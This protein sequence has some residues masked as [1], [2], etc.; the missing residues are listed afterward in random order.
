M[1]GVFF[2]T[3]QIVIQ[4][5]RSRPLVVFCYRYH[6]L[7]SLQISYKVARAL[8]SST[9]SPL[10]YIV[11]FHSCSLLIFTNTLSQAGFVLVPHSYLDSPM[12]SIFLSLGFLS[13]MWP[14]RSHKWNEPVVLRPT[15][16]ALTTGSVKA[17]LCQ[18]AGWQ[19]LP[20]GL[21]WNEF[22]LSV[23][24]VQKWVHVTHKYLHT[25]LLEH[26]Q[27]LL[28]NV[29]VLCCFCVFRWQLK[30]LAWIKMPWREG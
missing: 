15:Q 29:L 18:D 26:W 11:Q 5:K 20:S 12:A 10:T 16:T 22:P 25:C 9:P 1:H 19:P 7:A 8:D 6:Q 3:P 27:K 2:L 30:Q 14:D 17:L 28:W 4:V 23:E 13:N 21:H 24:L